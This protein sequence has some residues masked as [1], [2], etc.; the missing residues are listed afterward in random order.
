MIRQPSG[1]TG[2]PGPWLVC[3][4]HHVAVLMAWANLT[5]TVVTV[6]S[7]APEI[8]QPDYRPGCPV[9]PRRVRGPG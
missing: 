3:I 2:G 4:T 9:A 1:R 5:M 8:L 6:A 7:K